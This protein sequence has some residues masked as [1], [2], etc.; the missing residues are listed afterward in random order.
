MLPK[1]TRERHGDEYYVVETH[2]DIILVPVPKDPI[3]DLQDIGRR[4]GLDRYSI[5]QLRQM[6]LDEASEQLEK[7]HALR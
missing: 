3:K 4:A 6:A 1:D 7:R 5:R 2:N